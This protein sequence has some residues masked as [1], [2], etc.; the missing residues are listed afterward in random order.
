[1]GAADD[2]QRLTGSDD[3]ATGI[4][5]RGLSI[6]AALRSAMAGGSGNGAV[7]DRDTVPGEAPAAD[8]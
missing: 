4:A 1:M 3:V 6:Y 8:R 5:A 7:A 2:P